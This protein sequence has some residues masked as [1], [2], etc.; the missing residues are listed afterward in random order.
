MVPGAVPDAPGAADTTPL[1]AAVAAAAAGDAE[2]G[3][4]AATTR[5]QQS[6]WTWMKALTNVSK[7]RN[8]NTLLQRADEANEPSGAPS[9]DGAS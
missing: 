9:A 1:A 5:R 4:D 7:Q 6:R 2:G 3:V 8:P